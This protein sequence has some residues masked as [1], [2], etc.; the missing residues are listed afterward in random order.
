MCLAYMLD[1][2]LIARTYIKGGSYEKN[3]Q[4]TNNDISVLE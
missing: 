3:E 1:I 2:N 4:E